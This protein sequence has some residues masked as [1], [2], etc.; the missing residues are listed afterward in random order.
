MRSCRER[1]GGGSRKARENKMFQIK[2]EHIFTKLQINS[3]I[4]T[5]IPET[6]VAIQFTSLAKYSTKEG[7]KEPDWQG[8]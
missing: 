2:Q 4:S 3:I 8:S 5:E 7:K 6:K 1:S